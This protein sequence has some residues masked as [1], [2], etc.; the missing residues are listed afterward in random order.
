MYILQWPLLTAMRERLFARRLIKRLLTAYA[1]V[2][3]ANPSLA[4]KA[5]NR[6][7]LLHSREVELPRVDEVMELAESSVDEWTAPGRRD[8]GFR[9]LV[10]FLVLTRYQQQ[11]HLGSE[12]SFAAIV[13][14]LVPANL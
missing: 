13:E 4:G 2:A 3:R 12:V 7:V 9:E 11:G 14:E 5:L 10:H 8:L 1:S 6:E